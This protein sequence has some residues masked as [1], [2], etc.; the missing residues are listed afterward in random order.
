M[1]EKGR[2]TEKQ[3]SVNDFLYNDMYAVCVCVC[4]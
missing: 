4:V 1:E 2:V 3:L